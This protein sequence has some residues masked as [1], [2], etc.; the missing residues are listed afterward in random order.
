MSS[1]STCG[2]VL[3]LALSMVPIAACGGGGHPAR[4]TR[5][6][7][8]F[9]FADDL[10][11]GDLS[12]YGSREIDTPNLDQ[13][14][15]GGLLFTQAYAAN[16]VCTPSRAALLTGRYGAR[17]DLGPIDVFF[18]FS[19]DGFDPGEITI[20]ETLREVGYRTALVGKWHLGHLPRFL[21]MRQGFDEFYGLPYSNDMDEPHYPGEEPIERSCVSLRPDC[22]P[23][24]P[25]MEGETIIEM[26]AIQETLTRRYTTRAIEFMRASVAAERPFFLYY[27]S[28]FPHTPLYASDDFLGTSDG[29]LYGDVVEELDWSVGEIARELDAL[30]IADDTIVVFTSDNGPWLLWDTD[31]AVP[32][33]GLDSGSAG[34][35][36]EGK[37]S[38]FEGGHRVPQ[39]V[40]WP[41]H[42]A[43]G[44]TIT[45]PVSHLDWMPTLAA[46]AGAALPADREIDGRDIL[47]LLT[48]GRTPEPDDA[49]RFLYYRNT[50]TDLGGYR[51]GPWK[52]KLAVAEHEA[53]YA[54][55]THGDLLFNLEDDPGEQSDLAAA[56]PEMVAV[57]KER[58]QAADDRIRRSD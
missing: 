32:Q 3:S 53:I 48:G 52:L 56:E 20:A 4:A 12:S 55:Y 54:Q 7:I 21:P 29:G 38:T 10:G 27:A 57:L 24:V 16:N 41:A 2:T 9:V 15:A 35:L 36:R 30:G 11:Y 26:P 8:V 46:A 49:Y 14:A 19:F 18:P 1:S 17:T 5:P 23:G 34:A 39:I 6:N 58:M 50:N 42:I 51:E 43:A 45:H 33:G 40:R 31:R 25:L 28:N 22:R 47:A 44:Q 13:L 37:G